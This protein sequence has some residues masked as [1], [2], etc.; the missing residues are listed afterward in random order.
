MVGFDGSDG[1]HHVAADAASI[2][3]VSSHRVF[4]RENQS[5]TFPRYRTAA[6]GR[7]VWLN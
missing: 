5:A 2:V 6:T 7:Q 3:W 1:K 4:R